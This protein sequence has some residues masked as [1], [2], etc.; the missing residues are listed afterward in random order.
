M[1]SAG[2]KAAVR[3]LTEAIEGH[4]ARTQ[5][6]RAA[7]ADACVPPM[8]EGYFSKRASGQQGDLIEFAFTLPAEIRA[9]FF[10]RLAD[11]EGS[12]PFLLAAEQFVA[13]GVRLMR[14]AARKPKMVKAALR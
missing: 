9:E 10:Q 11:A 12:D 2:K 14:L 8:S 7:L 6:T 5:Q 13:M 4:L 3:F 1:E